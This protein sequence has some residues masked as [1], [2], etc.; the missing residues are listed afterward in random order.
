MDGVRPNDGRPW[1][2]I[3]GRS[4]RRNTPGRSLGLRPCLG[5]GLLSV[6]IVVDQCR[7][8]ACDGVP[9]PPDPNRTPRDPERQDLAGRGLVHGR[10]CGMRALIAVAAATVVTAS[11]ATPR[12]AN[13]ASS[14]CYP[15]CAGGD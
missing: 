9:R 11:L 8:L 13:A 6:R 12:V 7:W 3:G 14:P 2:A 15:F 4:A 10:R 5:A 1:S